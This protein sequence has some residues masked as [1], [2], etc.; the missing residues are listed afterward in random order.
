MMTAILVT[1]GN[2][3]PALVAQSPQGVAASGRDEDLEG[4]LEVQIE[5][6][7]TGVK[8]HHFLDTGNEKVR[9]RG[10]PDGAEFQG[11]TSGS[12]VRVHGR[13]SDNSTLELA[14]TGGNVTTLALAAPNTFGEQRTAVILVNFQ[15]DASQP[16]AWSHAANV[17]FGQVNDFYRENSY[18]QTWITGDVFGW[19][20]IPMSATSCDYNQIANLADQ[21]ATR[22]GA[23]LAPTRAS[24]TGFHGT[25]ARGGGSA[26]W[27][28]SVAR[29]SRAH[30]RSRSSRMSWATTSGTTIPTR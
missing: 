3:G 8:L 4:V 27:S 13:R 17:T 10:R 11:L 18:S 5:D 2:S 25:R 23:N 14:N 9:L 22:P 21:A 24:C 7:D 30:I 26:R 28:P 1:N 12:R 29:G 6:A 20:T 16:Y 15:D 19:F